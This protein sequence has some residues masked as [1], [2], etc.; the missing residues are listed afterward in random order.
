MKRLLWLGCLGALSVVA[1]VSCS[2]KTSEPVGQTAAAW[3]TPPVGP[4]TVQ[5]VLEL[6]LGAQP[7]DV[8]A[9]ATGG[10]T[11]EEGVHL[12]DS[13]GHTTVGNAGPG[14]TVA[15]IDTIVG[16][17]SGSTS[18]PQ[19]CQGVPRP[20]ALATTV[21]VVSAAPIS[22]EQD[23]EVTGNVLTTSP[24]AEQSGA[25][26]DGTVTIQPGPLFRS[27]SWSVTFPAVSDADLTLDAGQTASLAPGSYG[28]VIVEQGAT[29]TLAA[30]TYTFVSLAVDTGGTIQGNTASGPLVVYVQTSLHMYGSIV[31]SGGPSTFLLGYAGTS[32]VLV[33]TAFSGTFVAPKAAVTL[34]SLSNAGPGQQAIGHRGAFFAASLD[35]HQCVNVGHVPFGGWPAVL[36][37]GS[38]PH[39]S[40]P[41]P[42]PPPPLQE[43]CYV[44]TLSGTANGWRQVDCVG[45]DVV[46]QFFRK[47]NVDLGLGPTSSSS[48]VPLVF[49]QVETQV[50]TIDQETDAYDPVLANDPCGGGGPASGFAYTPDAWSVQTNTNFFACDQSGPNPQGIYNCAVQFTIQTLPNMTTGTVD[51]SQPG[52]TAICI[53][54]ANAGKLKCD[55]VQA[56]VSYTLQCVGNPNPLSGPD[57]QLTSRRGPLLP[58]DFADVAGY[59]YKDPNGNSMIGMVAQTTWATVPQPNA[60]VVPAEPVDVPGLYAVVAKDVYGLSGGGWTSVTGDLLGEGG[61]SKATFGGQNGVGGDGVITRVMASSCAGDTTASGP[62]CSSG[63]L[64]PSAVAITPNTITV[65]TNNLTLAGTSP[66]TYFNQNLAAVE[67]L[68]ALNPPAGG[69]WTDK[70][71]ATGMVR[72]HVYTKDNAGD[73]GG[74]PS[75]AGGVP[76][77]ESPDIFLLPTD[78]PRPDANTA[79]SADWTVT[80]N[81][82]YYIYVRV[83]NDG[84]NTVSNL[85]AALFLADPDL[86]FPD[87]GA[88]ITTG[89]QPGNVAYTSVA[90]F[91]RQVLGPFPFHAQ[92]SG[93]KCVLA[94]IRADGEP[95]PSLA[96]PP[97]PAYQDARVG[98]RNLQFL[99]NVCAYAMSNVP[100]VASFLQLSVSVTPSSAVPASITL[101]FTGASAQEFSNWAAI[102]SAQ[103]GTLPQGTHLSANA[104]NGSLV[105]AIS[106]TPDL[107]LDA[108]GLAPGDKPTVTVNSSP[109]VGSKTATVALSGTVMDANGVIL[110]QNGGSCSIT[111]TEIF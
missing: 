46:S 110:L 10:L 22:L 35:V 14:Q 72:N 70:D 93:H 39:V 60:T 103:S 5:F 25:K 89:Y 28:T 36:L 65:E 106:G 99:S 81:A 61:G 7:P 57:F 18:S 47:P 98:Q 91:S 77:W 1:A 76:F 82:D 97:P 71:P 32:S 20:P 105:V 95:G 101:T 87:W 80:Q 74:V 58:S 29:L 75:N 92:A 21:D 19:A 8:L 41:R 49:A 26:I 85:Q 83:N 102:W 86:G 96:S 67:F 108:V 11:L 27:V 9:V 42:L 37:Q 3:S 51:L 45:A 24:P 69:C 107:A 43:G 63:V 6:P 62:V 90:P 17:K 4:E 23:A 94:A 109:P 48:A 68:E 100:Q 13:S 30:G 79:V 31:P 40:A 59:T 44:G 38:L 88:A 52:K 12:D 53:T 78:S 2:S 50:V 34:A 55:P 16:D 84:C 104:S 111:Q 73:N 56:D 33:E 66:V 64:S 15:G 54:Q